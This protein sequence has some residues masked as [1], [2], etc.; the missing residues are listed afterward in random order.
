MQLLVY[1]QCIKLLIK[2]INDNKGILRRVEQVQV[3]RSIAI[4][5]IYF[6]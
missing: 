4:S 6:F 1:I 5:M 2:I 3:N